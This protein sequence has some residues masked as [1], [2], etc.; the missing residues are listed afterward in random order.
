MLQVSFI[1]VSRKRP[2]F[3][4]TPSFHLREPFGDLEGLD[5]LSVVTTKFGSQLWGEMP[6]L[7]NFVHVL[8]F[9]CF[10][11]DG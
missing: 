10:P 8:Y 3:S 7:R 2:P 5:L 11:R 1:Q 4:F 9:L 6:F